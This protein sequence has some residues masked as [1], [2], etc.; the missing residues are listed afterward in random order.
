MTPLYLCLL[1]ADHPGPAP[2]HLHTM[3]YSPVMGTP[4]CSPNICV[5]PLFLWTHPLLCLQWNFSSSLLWEPHLS[6]RS[7]SDVTFCGQK[8]QNLPYISRKQTIA[9]L[10]GSHPALG[11][12]WWW[13]WPWKPFLHVFLPAPHWIMSDSRAGFLFYSSLCSHYLAKHLAPARN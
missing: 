1:T 6:F 9:S 12:S 7:S 3:G 11:M 13:S 5:V 4:R 8:A 2:Y 10:P